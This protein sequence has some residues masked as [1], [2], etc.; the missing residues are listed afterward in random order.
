MFPL[1][2][3]GS[4]YSNTVGWDCDLLGGQSSMQQVL[5]DS[6]VSIVPIVHWFCAPDIPWRHSLDLVSAC[7]PEGGHSKYSSHS[8]QCPS[9]GKLYFLVFI[10]EVFVSSVYD[11]PCMYVR[12]FKIRDGMLAGSYVC[13]Y[14]V[15]L[16]IRLTEGCQSVGNKRAREQHLMCDRSKLFQ[17]SWTE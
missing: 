1:F 13:T 9:I 11:V 3:A 5:S 6:T 4:I 17:C 10:G 15:S 12:V 7:I 16:G 14:G 8:P 2:D